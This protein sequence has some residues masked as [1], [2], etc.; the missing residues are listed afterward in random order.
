MSFG[1]E[2]S[3]VAS[4]KVFRLHAV[5]RTIRLLL[6]RQICCHNIIS[7]SHKYEQ[8]YFKILFFVLS[9]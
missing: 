5:I 8:K 9:F 1:R 2:S 3:D 4:A 7:V 6:F